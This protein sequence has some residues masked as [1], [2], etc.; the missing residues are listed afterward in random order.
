M[1]STFPNAANF[2][3][4]Q[5][6]SVSEKE[7]NRA[8]VALSTWYMGKEQG[9]YKFKYDN[10]EDHAVTLHRVN[11]TFQAYGADVIKVHQWFSEMDPYERE[12]LDD[13]RDIGVSI[14][15]IVDYLRAPEDLNPEGLPI[16][17]DMA[18]ALRLREFE[19]KSKKIQSTGR[20]AA[21]LAGS[22]LILTAGAAVAAPVILPAVAPSL[23]PAITTA[24]APV[25]AYLP[26]LQSGA[27]S[28]LHLAAGG[29]AMALSVKAWNNW[30]KIRG[31]PPA[32]NIG[33]ENDFKDMPN[34]LGNLDYK[35]ITDEYQAIPTADRYLLSHLSESEMRL[36]LAGSDS[37]RKHVLSASPPSA[38]SKI[39]SRLDSLAKG[40]KGFPARARRL[41][42]VAYTILT[43]SWNR[44][45]GNGRI[46][47]LEKRMERWRAAA[48]V[49]TMGRQ[50]D[51]SLKAY[52][53]KGYLERDA[54]IS[55]VPKAH[56]L[57][58][59]LRG[60][61]L[62]PQSLSQVDSNLTRKAN[63]RAYVNMGA[64]GQFKITDTPPNKVKPDPNKPV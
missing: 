1:R 8:C 38:W 36:F 55:F 64:F 17:S 35:K 61:T 19:A 34:S 46:P 60:H 63:P 62:S 5:D 56:S 7:I 9:K 39:Q 6:S 51:L 44:E 21:I 32:L 47:D 30:Q 43:A 41:G 2:A 26:T 22:A 50:E 12:V 15:D 52:V 23:A 25:A 4:A 40:K 20:S 18:S 11:A 59:E 29:G 16:R 53:K 13:L 33:A 57:P 42:Q 27:M 31:G 48:R 10:E 3:A 49:N 24:L 45:S 54:V 28:L 14:P 58:R 37:V